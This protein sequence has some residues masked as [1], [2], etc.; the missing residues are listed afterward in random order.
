MFYSSVW[1][2]KKMDW[3]FFYNKNKVILYMTFIKTEGIYWYIL[4]KRLSKSRIHSS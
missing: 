1:L 3:N 4:G 2:L